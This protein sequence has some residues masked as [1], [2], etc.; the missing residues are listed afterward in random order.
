MH[1]T[2]SEKA[3][4]EIVTQITNL[5]QTN[6]EYDFKNFMRYLLDQDLSDL[7]CRMLLNKH[8]YGSLVRKA[9]DSNGSN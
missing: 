4:R 2:L 5:I 3:E 6:R 9:K 1:N 7:R 8:V